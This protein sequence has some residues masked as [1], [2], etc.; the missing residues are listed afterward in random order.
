MSFI[1][2]TFHFLHF[3][4][5][6]LA[7][8]GMHICQRQEEAG[9][10]WI[11]KCSFASLPPLRWQNTR[12]IEGRLE[13]LRGNAIFHDWHT[14][15]LN[16]RG[17]RFTLNLMVRLY[18]LFW[19]PVK[20]IS[21]SW[22]P[23]HGNLSDFNGETLY[24]D[25]RCMEIPARYAWMEGRPCCFTNSSK[26]SHQVNLKSPTWLKACSLWTGFSTGGA[27]ALRCTGHCGHSQMEFH[28]VCM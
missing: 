19:C 17:A 24:C 10:Q 25:S 27:G 7:I 9:V 18:R 3:L 23:K 20:S 22:L 15:F 12:K 21:N 11:G 1:G 26:L 4:A 13:T 5:K 16:T 14:L 2:Q 8:I 28:T 6:P